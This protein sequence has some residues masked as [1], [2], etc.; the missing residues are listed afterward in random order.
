MKLPCPKPERIVLEGRYARLEPLALAH[1][2]A[3]LQA[4]ADAA[5][6]DYLFAV[7]KQYVESKRRSS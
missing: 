6:F 7:D 5:S 4:S 3:L 1:A 2:E